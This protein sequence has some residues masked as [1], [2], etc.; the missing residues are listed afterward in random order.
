M[1]KICKKWEDR[2][3]LLEENGGRE[4]KIERKTAE[5]RNKM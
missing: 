1:C 4:E 3:W 2:K 5:K